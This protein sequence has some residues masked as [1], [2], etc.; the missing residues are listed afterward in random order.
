MIKNEWEKIARWKA[1]S[2]NISWN[3]GLRMRFRGKF[4]INREKETDN[5]HEL[6]L[7]VDN[8]N[9]QN[10]KGA[11]NFSFSRI[12]FLLVTCCLT[13]WQ[14][15]MKNADDLKQV[16]FHLFFFLVLNVSHCKAFE[17]KCKWVISQF[18]IL[19][20]TQ[21]PAFI[22]DVVGC[23]RYSLWPN[24]FLWAASNRNN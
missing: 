2:R 4:L 7:T 1:P 22:G 11:S 10:G 8:L 13:F 5:R 9:M 23:S 17:W 16:T 21:W 15:W 19:E 6:M 14:Y 24:D 3:T 12:S 20:K 18:Q